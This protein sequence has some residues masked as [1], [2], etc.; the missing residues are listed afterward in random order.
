VE[1]KALEIYLAPIEHL[2]SVGQQEP[3]VE[4]INP[5]SRTYYYHMKQRCQTYIAAFLRENKQVLFPD[6]HL[7]FPQFAEQV[8]KKFM[9]EANQEVKDYLVY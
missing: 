1:T 6:V 5:Y 9:R 2:Y 8:L 3:L 7:F 4:V